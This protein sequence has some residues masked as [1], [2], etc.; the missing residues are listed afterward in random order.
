[1]VVA[2]PPFALPMTPVSENVV[3]PFTTVEVTFPRAED[4]PGEAAPSVEGL[5]GRRRYVPLVV[6]ELGDGRGGEVR[7]AEVR[8][9]REVVRVVRP[10]GD[11]GRGEV[12]GREAG[13][14]REEPRGEERVGAERRGRRGSAVRAPDDAR[15]RNVVLPFTTVEVTFP[16]PRT[17]QERPPHPLRDW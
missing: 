8:A 3:L 9:R 15:E 14:G 6:R 16:E 13:R 12:G 10:L 17:L 7:D 11:G 4:A 2:V 5:V 1:M